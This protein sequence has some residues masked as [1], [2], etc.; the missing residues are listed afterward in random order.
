MK[1][2]HLDAETASASKREVYQTSSRKNTHANR[3]STTWEAK[4]YF[5]YT[6]SSSREDTYRRKRL[7][8]HCLHGHVRYAF[9]LVVDD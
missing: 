6:R 1:N 2:R 8:H 7:V 5:S 3:S 4:A 9:Q